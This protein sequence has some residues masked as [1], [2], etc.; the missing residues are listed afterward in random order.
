M[1]KNYITIAFRNFLRHK[2]FTFLN[3]LGLSLGLAASLLILQ[4]VKYEKSYDTFHTNAENIYRVQYN[5]YQNNQLTIEC[6][7]AVPAVGPALKNNFPEVKQFTR[8]FPFSG[9]VNYRSTGGEDVT[10]REEKMQITDP[11][12][13]E[14]FDFKLIQG[15]TETSLEGPNKAVISESAAQKFFGEED[16]MGKYITLD[17]TRRAEVT[18]IFADVPD[19]SHIKFNILFSYQTLNNETENASETAWG[20]YDFNTYVLIDPSADVPALQSKWDTYLQNER[21][22]DW[23]KYNYKQEFILQPLLDIHLYSNLLQESMPEEQG[24]GNAVYFLT[25]IALFILIIAWVNYINLATAKSFERANEVGVRKVMGANK[26]QLIYQFLA[27]SFLINLLATFLA[28][29]IIRLAWPSFA[30]LAGRNIPA[31]FMT[32]QGFWVTVAGLFVVGAVL[33]GSY[34]A[35]VLSS[36]KPVLVLKGKLITSKGSILRQLLVI[37]QFVASIFL[38]SGTIIVYQ[39]LS[40]MQNRDLGIDLNQTLVLKGPDVA[41]SLYEQN[42][43]S[44]KNESLKIAGV[45][46]LSAASN[47]PGDE[48]FWTQGIRRLQGGPESGVIVYNVGI[49]ED[50]IPAFNLELLAGRNFEKEITGDRERILMNR[51]LAETLEFESPE[52]ALGE[53]VVL[54]NDTLEI[55]GILENYHQMSLKNKMAP[56]ALRL[57]P[58]R[59]FFSFKIETDNYQQVLTSLEKPWKIIFPGNPIDYFF[60]DEFFNQQYRS[61]RQFGQVFGLFSALAIFVACLGLFGLASFMT[62]QRTK[63]IGV[64]K[65]LGSTV[66]NIVLLLSTGFIRLVIIANL[67]AWPLAW[68]VMKNW[69]ESFPYHMDINPLLFPFAGLG[70]IIVAFLSVGFQT[71]RAA[72]LNPAET[73]KYE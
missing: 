64:R 60:L 53:K 46:K 14:V 27:E 12:V 50:Y 32:E 5:V 4:Y 72:L 38:I 31:D 61:D 22:E 42:F 21:G 10:F 20:W 55:A 28:L 59:N 65:V 3:V 24:D 44:F 2:S 45:K 30:S 67:I 34:P 73:L 8:L 54:G 11:A 25:I 1:I 13:F 63:E 33:S 9:T 19:N 17:G 36:F 23:N 35:L 41:D 39:Q 62:I 29:V 68:W 37:F 57:F 15:S 48:I 43:E 71:L 51:A 18:G 66:A 6:A 26:G 47:V 58:A 56:I 70:V 49:D 69:L 52:A 16:P 40:F 7:A